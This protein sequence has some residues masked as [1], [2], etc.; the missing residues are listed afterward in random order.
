MQGLT[1]L[2]PDD[3]HRVSCVWADAGLVRLVRMEYTVL[4]VQKLGLNLGRTWGLPEKGWTGA[5]EFGMIPR[6]A[7][8]TAPGC[9]RH[10]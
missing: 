7:T 6:A 5:G 3:I 2:L 8:R 1:P 4:V 10:G 9:R